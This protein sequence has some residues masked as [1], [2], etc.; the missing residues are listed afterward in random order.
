MI[1]LTLFLTFFKIGL[2]TLGGGYAMIPLIQADVVGNGWMSLEQFIDFIAVAESTPGPFA[3]NTATFVGF[4]MGGPLGAAAATLGVVLPSFLIILFIAKWFMSFQDNFYVRSAMTG[5]R[6]VILG[7]I[8]SAAF[9]IAVANFLPD[10]SSFYAALSS[11]NVRGL[12][13]FGIILFL[14]C[15]WKLHPIWLIVISGVLGVLFFGVPEM[16]GMI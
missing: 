10:L 13:I 7:L 8:S 3:V 4:R 5:L 15:K 11:V 16:M 2:F 9:T 6:P 1:L 12:V 14:N